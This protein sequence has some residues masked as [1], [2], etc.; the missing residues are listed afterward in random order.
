MTADELSPSLEAACSRW[1]DRVALVHRGR[2]LTYGQLWAEV[3]ALARGYRR[4]GIAPGDRIMCALATTPMHIVAAHAAW[5]CGAV[6]VGAH[7]DLTGPELATLVERL[8]ARG[9]LLEPMDRHGD[10]STRRRTVA[11]SCPGLMRIVSEGTPES[12]ELLLADLLAEA[13]SAEPG[14]SE[15][16]LDDGGP[17]D[18]P[19]T[20]ESGPADLV[21]FTSG[22]T[23]VPKAVCETLAALQAKVD[24]FAGF[25]RP[26]PD[27]VHLLYLPLCH[28]F[29]LK[30]S[31]LALRSG[32]RLVLVDRFYPRAVLDVMASEQVTVLAGTPT[33][34]TLLLDAVDRGRHGDNHL[35]WVVTAAAPLSPALAEQ[36]YTHLGAGLFVVYG[37]S[38]GFLT[39]TADR[40]EILRGS[41]GKEVF[42]SP[43]NSPAGGLV[44]IAG[45]NESM[46]SP[47]GEVGEIVYST[48]GPVRYWDAPATGAD[49]WYRSGDMGRID[50]H[51]G[52]VVLGR[53]KELVNRGG[54]K[55]SPVEVEAALS[56]HPDI[57]DVAVIGTPDPVLGEAV[58]ACVVSSCG[59]TPTV[60]ELRAFLCPTLAHHKLPDEVC[61]LAGI[62][63][64]SLGKVERARLR[65]MVVDE[66]A[67][68]ER[69]RSRP[70]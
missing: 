49:G 19:A 6:H 12:G 23:G 25:V 44:S 57:A 8:D 48:A 34:L 45:P 20:S 67:P 52:L 37:C 61:Y 69:L 65:S 10:T 42:A 35:R 9:L 50:A 46:R 53:L 63:R 40:D 14:S 22:T 32:G 43:A 2:A 13:G 33:H 68:R 55:V 7:P 26:G 16:R 30:L 56:R 21:F 51:G 47:P 38:E 18:P 66:G 64:S 11:L 28:A 27:D 62:P 17:T 31:L 24:F 59:V 41:V 29:G 70:H 60:A 4:L 1:P 58:C 3:Q 5:A 15:P 39:V 54:L 36:V